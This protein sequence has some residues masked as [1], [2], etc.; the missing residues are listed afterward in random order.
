M[1]L[2]IVLDFP[3]KVGCH[4][5]YRSCKCPEQM[6]C[7]IRFQ[8]NPSHL[9]NFRSMPDIGLMLLDYRAQLVNQPRM[10]RQKSS[11]FSPVH[12]SKSST[13]SPL[14]SVHTNERS[15]YVMLKVFDWMNEPP[16]FFGARNFALC[17]FF[18]RARFRSKN[19]SVFSFT[20]V[21]NPVREIDAHTHGLFLSKPTSLTLLYK[22]TSSVYDE[23]ILQVSLT[24]AR[25]SIPQSI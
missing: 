3:P 7:L 19:S 4:G 15:T 11:K 9:Q 21:E 5:C 24:K 6:R 8:R 1:R 20:G 12:Q 2:F 13:H 22:Y 10:S 18:L 14:N 23:R 17:F 25:A 16:C